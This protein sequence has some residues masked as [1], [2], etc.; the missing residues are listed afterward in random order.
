[1][2]IADSQVHIWTHNTPQRPWREGQNVHRPVPLEADDLVREM[3]AAGVN[4]AILVPP[5]LDA[6]RNDLSLDAARRYP[7]RFAVMGRLDPQAAGSAAQVAV[8]R[9]QPGML[10]LRYTLNRPQSLAV[11]Q[12]GSLDWLWDAAEKAGVPVMMSI[13]H[14]MAPLVDRIAERPPGLK[15]VL[16]YFGVGHG[17]YDDDAFRDFE[18]FVALARRPNVAVKAS[19]L[20]CFSKAPYPYRPLHP[21]IRRAYDAFGPR[22]MFWGTDFSRLPCSYRQAITLFTEE[23]PWLTAEDKDWIMGRGLCEWLG[24][25]V[26]KKV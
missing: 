8:W 15:V 2:L 3:D 20:P 18:Q 13:R 25:P 26:G 10:G 14:T 12:E 21:Y 9:K 1:M 22:R 23:L 6:D 11:L 19:A 17:V 5:S 16:D 24:W 4:R 7:S